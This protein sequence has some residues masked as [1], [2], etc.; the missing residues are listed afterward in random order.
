ME[1]I[2][3]GGLAVGA[4]ERMTGFMVGG[5]HLKTVDF[6]GLGIGAYN[7]VK[8]RQEGITIGLVNRATDLHGV[9]IGL[10]NHAAN[11]PPHFRWLPFV[12]VHID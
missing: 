8:G 3:L 12:N 9:Q 4:G 11:N 5:A 1:G 10:I 6:T 7:L 2:C